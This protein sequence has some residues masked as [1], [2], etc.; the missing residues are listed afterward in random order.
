MYNNRLSILLQSRSDFLRIKK[1][2]TDDNLHK[3]RLLDR[4]FGLG[5]GGKPYKYVPPTEG[6]GTSQVV[7][8]TKFRKSPSPIVIQDDEDLN[9]YRGDESRGDAS[10][11]IPTFAPMD[12]VGDDE[13]TEEQLFDELN[14]I[15]LPDIEYTEKDFGEEP[16]FS[17]PEEA[18]DSARG[19]ETGQTSL[20][21]GPGLLG[22]IIWDA[23][24]THVT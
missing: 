19:R 21:P 12:T 9:V 10:K 20:S 11:E 24:L 15:P 17:A 13:L 5:T 23:H 6:E 22:G 8:T 16:F 2:I 18:A 14:K 1:C 7:E 3:H 4:K